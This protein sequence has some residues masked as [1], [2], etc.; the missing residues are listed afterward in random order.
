MD[1]ALD[2]KQSRALDCSHCDLLKM[3]LRNCQNKYGKSRSPILVNGNVYFECPRSSV[4]DQWDLGYL[5]SL[6]FDCKENNT[7]PFGN[8]LLNVTA[9]C[10]NVFDIMDSIVNDYRERENKKM[11]DSINKDMKKT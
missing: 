3:R 6:Y 8:S 9:F 1:L 10:K 4:V 7:Y 2:S 5:V 11:Q